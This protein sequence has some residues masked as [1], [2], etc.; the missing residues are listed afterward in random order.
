MGERIEVMQ[1]KVFVSEMEA[2]GRYT[3]EKIPK[4]D[5]TWID[6]NEQFIATPGGIWSKVGGE[7]EGRFYRYSEHGEEM[8]MQ[9][10]G[11][12]KSKGKPNC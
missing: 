4:R 12:I 1:T 7:G 3:E 9:L 5:A 11:L 2:K 8:W 6:V 10:Y